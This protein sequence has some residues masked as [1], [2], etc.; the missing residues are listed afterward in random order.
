[1]RR[2]DP[3]R[4]GP[5]LDA[6]VEPPEAVDIVP[7]LADAVALEPAAGHLLL[8]MVGSGKTSTARRIVERVARAAGDGG[9][10][11]RYVD[12]A[13]HHM[14]D[15]EALRGVLLAVSGLDLADHAGALRKFDPAFVQ[16]AGLVREFARGR[17]ADPSE[18]EDDEPWHEGP[19]P[20][21]DEPPSVFVPGV[22]KA[23]PP[24][25]TDWY[26]PHD[27]ETAAG[28]VAAMRDIYPGA[29]REVLYAFD[30][31]DRLR[32]PRRFAEAVRHDIVALRRARIGHVVVGPMRF[33][34]G[35]D[36]TVRQLFGDN[37]H[38]LPVPHPGVP[39]HRRFLME[40]LRRR[41]GD[42][43]LGDDAAATVAAW[44]G[45]LC[46]DALS[47]AHRAGQEAYSRGAD[48]I[49]ELDVDRAALGRGD[50]LAFGLDMEARAALRTVAASGELPTFGDRELSL[51]DSGRVIPRGHRKWS[52]HPCL[53]RVLQSA[54]AAA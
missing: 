37:I 27:L 42:T 30:S 29:S 46:R 39:E 18:F 26:I 33:A 36:S 44:S 14:L 45:G 32:D 54:E 5:A 23:P 41:G 34:L 31:L 7:G 40:I 8:G 49:E 24:G 50:A 47:I 48:R 35:T 20:D 43:V 4:L 17:W 16:A 11:V 19:P 6:F 2:V 25:P 52:V 12:V 28:A 22:L 9:D 51:V 1:M 53:A 15:A 10:V 13:A 3:T 21:D 38:V